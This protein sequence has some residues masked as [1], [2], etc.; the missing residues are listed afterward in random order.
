MHRQ[1]RK[2][3]FPWGSQAWRD[4]YARLRKKSPDWW[5]REQIRFTN[6][7]WSCIALRNER[8]GAVTRKGKACQAKAMLKS[9]RCRC[10]GGLS[11]GP[12]TDEGKARAKANLL[13]R[14]KR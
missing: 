4:E 9:G 3:P 6:S 2:V 7:A 14:W 11:T 8:C 13:L 12:R 10:H 1:D 5:A